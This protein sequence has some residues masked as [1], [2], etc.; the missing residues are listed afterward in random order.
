MN[1]FLLHD[2]L[3]NTADA[4]PNKTAL[5]F[6]KREMTYSELDKASNKLAR[7][8]NQSG[9]R[10]GDRVGI[11]LNKCPEALISVFGIL[12]AGAAYVPIDP[13]I[14]AGRARFIIDNCEIRHLISSTGHIKRLTSDPASDPLQVDNIV[15]TDNAEDLPP[16]RIDRSEVVSLDSLIS[17]SNGELNAAKM[18]DVNPAYILFTSGSTG[19]PKGVVISHANALTFVNMASE[20]FKITD[21]D[22]FASHAPLHFDLSV[23]DI[24]VA[25]KCGATTVLVPEPLSTFPIRLAEHIHQNE[26]SIWN[27]AASVLVQLADRGKM[28]RFQFDALRIVH[29]SGDVMPLK[30]LRLLK[31]FMPKANFYNIYG[32]TEANSSLCYHVGD[33]SY[34]DGR[35]IPIGKAFPNFEVFALSDDHQVIS[36]PGQDGE[37]YVKSSTVA[38]GYWRDPILSRKKFVPDP[39]NPYSQDRIYRTGDVV[40]IGED[41]NYY[42][43]GRKDHMVKSRGYRIELPEIE[44]VITSHPLVRHAAAIPVPDELI[45][46]K[47][48]AYISLVEGGQLDANTLLDFCAMQLPKYMIPELFEFRDSLPMTSSGKID[49]KSLAQEALSKYGR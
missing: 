33:V 44:Y 35:P 39:R 18:S 15:V 45:G 4:A 32:Q 43:A 41:G 34:A 12:K 1:I 40:R 19:Q 8:L 46:N 25:M 16:R 11:L 3:R 23:F 24:Y 5:V 42:F 13:Q 27:S 9:V 7:Y 17:Q 22:R 2:L 14:P 6:R 10:I 28:D 26:I 20:Y 49:R 29:F 47:I 21:R 37:L 38:M 31:K 36:G 48:L 30:Y